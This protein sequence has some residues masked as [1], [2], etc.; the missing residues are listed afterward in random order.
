[1][2]SENPL[3]LHFLTDITC[4]VLFLKHYLCDTII[5]MYLAIF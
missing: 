1:M 4:W 5:L 2:C 3:Y